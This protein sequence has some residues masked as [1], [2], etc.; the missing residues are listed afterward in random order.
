MSST[1]ENLAEMLLPSL[2]FRAP[3]LLLASLPRIAGA[4]T[5]ASVPFIACFPTVAGILLLLA[6]LHRNWRPNGWWWFCCFIRT[7][8]VLVVHAVVGAPSVAGFQL[9]LAHLLLLI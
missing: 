7:C 4:P 6:S 2:L 1:I 8:C 5:V 9:L 3:L